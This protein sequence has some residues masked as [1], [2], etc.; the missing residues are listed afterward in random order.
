M[1]FRPR[2]LPL[3]AAL[4]SLFATLLALPAQGQT[5]N[6][7]YES[8]RGFDA[9][10]QGARAQY[11]ASVARA[12]QAKAGILPAVGLTAGATRNNLDIDTLTGAGRGTTTP[13]DFTTQN[14]GINATQPL[15]RPANWATYEQGKRQAEIAQAVL[16]I[17]EQDLIVRVSQAYF[18][19]LA[20]QDSLTLVRAQKVAVAEQLASAKRNFEVGTSTITDT[21]EAQARYDLVI[22]QE[23]AAENDLQV[24]KVVLDQLVGR[25]GSVPVPLAQP[26]VLPAATPAN[27]EAWVAQA[28]EAH[29]AIRQA[30]LGLDVAGLEIRKA[31]AGHKP[32]LDANLGYNITRNPHGT[33]TSTVGTRIDAASVGVV[34]NLPLFAGFAT[35]N[36]IKETLALE[37]QSRSV[38]EGTRRSV[39]QATRAAYLGLVSGAGQV[40]AL[41]AAEASSQSALDA[42]R[43]GYQVGVRI[44]ID[45]LNSQSQLYQTKRDLAQAR[46]N[47]LLGNLKLRQAN[48]TLTV[49]DMNA[50]NATLA[51]NGST[52]PP[53]PGERPQAAPSVPVTP[54]PIPVVPPVPVQPF[55]PPAPTMPSAPPPPV[56][57]NP[58]VR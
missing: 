29:P 56:I 34:F 5:L 22:A 1:P 44:N 51:K 55:N 53:A 20:S 4:A 33:S 57:L 16:T 9:T 6:E 18:D 17:S 30:R 38:L 23:I 27:I 52:V 12:A 49:D 24:K 31:E 48:G 26:V 7:L 41:E 58:P 45:V 15:Y 37:D 10:Y 39:A 11:D 2:L 21:R 40:K 54:P 36:R 42:N 13:R 35:E 3:S 28:E 46:Y 25:P 19:V 14:I 43:L 8:A 47:V 50:I 32:T